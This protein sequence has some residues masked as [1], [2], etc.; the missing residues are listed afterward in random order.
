MDT[1]VGTLGFRMA[2]TVSGLPLVL[3][4][5][6]L[7]PMSQGCAGLMSTCACVED[8]SKGHDM[9]KW[10]K[11]YCIGEELLEVPDP[12]V[13]PE[14]TT[15]MVLS[16]N[17]IT[18]LKNASF[19]GLQDLERI[20][21]KNNRISRIWPGAFLGLSGLKR[22][23]LSNNRIG[24][25]MG[26]MFP[27]LTGL[28]RLNISGNIF[29]HL[30]AGF[31][32]EMVS[33]KS[34]D[35]GTEY[36]TCDCNMHWLLVWSRDKSVQISE[37]TLCA[38][39]SALNGRAFKSLKE[40]ELTCDIPLELHT[41]QLIPSLRQV[42]F[43]G[44]R[45]PFQCTATYLDNSTQIWW[46]HNGKPVHEDE[47]QGVMLVDSIIH[48]CTWITSELILSNIHISADGEWECVVST[49]RGNITKKVEITVL[50]TSASYC[51]A[52]RVSNNRGDFRW[53]RTLA[54][55]TAYQPCLQ[56][57]FT[58]ISVNGGSQEK[59]ASRR[60]G[61]TGHWE[62][63][64]YSNCLYTNDITR[65]LHTFVL[66]P[67]NASNALTSA[68]QLCVYTAEAANFSDMMDVIYVAQMFEKFINYVDQIKELGDVIIE[69]ASNL[70]MVEEHILWMAQKEEKACT[71][72]VQSVEKIASLSLTSNAQD[73]SLNARNIALEAYWIKPA[74]FIGLGCTAFQ[75][76]ESTFVSWSPAV[77][78]R[79]RREQHESETLRDP[80]LKFRCATGISNISLSS[81]P[82]KNSI[83]L[84]SVHLPQSLF[85]SPISS[86]SSMDCKLQFVVF[87]NGKL[88]LSTGNSSRLADDGKRRSVSTPVIFTGIDGCLIRNLTDPI[89]VSLRHFTEGVDPVA[90]FWNFDVL[91]GYGGWSSEGCQIA[92][93]ETNITTITCGHLNNLAVLMKVNDFPPPPPDTAQVLH[94]VIYTCTT[95]LLLCLFTTII[96]YIINH[97]TIHISRK[98]WHI[99]LNV[100]FH[101]AMTSAVFAGGINLTNYH[102]ICQAV[103][104]ILHY[105]SLSTLLWMGVMI[106]VIYKDVTRKV[107][108]QQEGDS[109][110]PTQRPMLRFYLIA[111]G[112]PLIICGITA[113]VNINNYGDNSHCWLVWRPSLGAFYVPAAFILLI[114]WIYFLCTR[115]NLRHCSKESKDPP[116]LNEG[117]Q[118]LGGSNN[119]L[120]ESGSASTAL[121]TG[122]QLPV[123]D[124]IYSLKSQF[125][126]LLAVHCLYIALW[127]FGALAVSL[128]WYFDVLLSCL[129]G[130]TAVALGLFI[131]IYHCFKR[132]DVQNSWFACCASNSNALPMQAY[133]HPSIAM[134]DGCQVFTSYNSDIAHS[135]KSSSSP[136][137]SNSNIGHCK[138][139]NLQ[140]AQSQAE[141]APIKTTCCDENEEANNKNLSA[142]RYTNSLQ[143]RRNHKSRTKQQRDGKHHRLKMLKGPSSEQPSS[144]SGSTHNSH[145][146]SYQS[147]RNSP[148]SNGQV[149]G[150]PQENEASVTQSEGSD[151]S[152]QQQ[153]NQH[154][155]TRSHRKCTSRDNLKQTNAAE[156]ETKRRS[157]PLNTAAPNGVLKGSKYDVNLAN[158]ENTAGMRTGLWKSETTV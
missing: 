106:R 57:P 87:R 51:P 77:Q 131:L 43:Q 82:L 103:G 144:E 62:D 109:P 60:C 40:K 32:D 89:T 118:R 139:T 122:L 56:Y 64:D 157:Y 113:A 68:H 88:F 50:E 24:C 48:D 117:E 7:C 8:R 137:S 90:A 53:P 129:Y 75:K 28:T 63:G 23:D 126:A 14:K 52:E 123:M 91:G 102:V 100:C 97:S 34:V 107:P 15:T 111:G 151:T 132:K 55:I 17:M 1:K 30:Q 42:V 150:A 128:E 41:H 116:M 138:L 143:S 101:I 105:S 130:V 121:N 46:Y 2:G 69:M 45:L 136:S 158:T 156:M 147:S 81:F 153:P 141:N 119:Y 99:L 148:L 21:L 65:A 155:Y 135:I 4:L 38:Y 31:F 127:V 120:T 71:S 27:G 125:G 13:I 110:Q 33:L 73:L 10:V 36:L 114:T 140:V 22:L 70:M 124:N 145:S 37:K 12:I 104:I 3:I 133:I 134:D 149:G 66:M 54:G 93:A 9:S 72:I 26:D 78:Q 5:L 112:I 86:T 47:L 74:N 29:S 83:A 98:G 6:H 76:R 49:S 19:Y 20:D 108:Q 92:Y 39:P 67:I 95:I 154:G 11:V 58:P 61:R 146:E 80:R 59:R 85:A 44:D 152:S 16:N 18:E 96:T 25:L 84:A 115:I 79:I 35:F 94:P 142:P